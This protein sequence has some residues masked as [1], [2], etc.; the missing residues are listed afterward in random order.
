MEHESAICQAI[1]ADFGGRPA[2]ETEL[3]EI[4]P[5]LEEVKGAL[6]HGRRWMKPR[7]AG[8]GK[9]FLPA[10]AQVLPQP[11]GVVGIIVPWNYPLY[12]A[13]GP[14][15]AALAAGNRAMVKMSEFTPGFSTLLQQLCAQAFSA[16]GGLPRHRGC[17][18]GGA[19]QRTALRPPAV[20]RLHAGGPQGDGAR[21]PPT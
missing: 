5:S 21:P 10:R 17:R 11:L 13:I 20:H 14:L 2:I 3:A 1:D 12:L 6:R 9:W 8:V 15:V 7:R 4:W 18:S 16:G 19:V